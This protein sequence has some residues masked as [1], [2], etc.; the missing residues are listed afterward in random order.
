MGKIKKFKKRKTRQSSSS[1]FTKECKCSFHSVFS[2]VSGVSFIGLHKV[3]SK[4]YKKSYL[5]WLIKNGYLSEHS[6][7]FC[8][9]CLKY[10][11]KKLNEN[12]G[13][14]NVENQEGL[15]NSQ[16]SSDS[17]NETIGNSVAYVLK[18]IKENKLNETETIELCRALGQLSKNLFTKIVNQFKF[19]SNTHYLQKI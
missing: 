15:E 9:G 8:N 10:A 6:K 19:Q 1:L 2:E 5:K 13:T 12:N 17:E 11:Q 3:R 7:Y 4:D 18:L 16:N 14:V